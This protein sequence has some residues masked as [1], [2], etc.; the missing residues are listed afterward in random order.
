MHAIDPLYSVCGL[1]G[2]LLVGMTGVGATQHQLASSG[3]SAGGG[4]R[5]HSSLLKRQVPGRLG[6]TG[7]R[8][9]SIIPHSTDPG[10][11]VEPALPRSERGVL[12]LDDPGTVVWAMWPGPGSNRHALLAARFKLAASSSSATGPGPERGEGVEPS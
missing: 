5:T 6:F 8:V 10:A 7:G 1:V 3:A 11:G 4:T 12:P 9:R 2:G